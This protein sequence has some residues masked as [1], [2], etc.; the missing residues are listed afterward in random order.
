MKLASRKNKEEK[1]THKVSLGTLYDINKNLIEKNVKSLTNEE[2]E[3]KK[4][5]IIDFINQ[6]NNEYYMLLCNDKKDYTIFHRS[7]K[8]KHGE[9]LDRCEGYTG[10]LLEQVLINECIPN[11][12]TAKSVELTDDEAAIE[13]WLSI[14]G[15][16]YCYYFFPYDSAIIEV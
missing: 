9:F 13:I 15:E 7:R 12:G 3:D 2:L 6:S 10:D 1:Q 8:S 4:D 14:D 11:R 5:L 16:S